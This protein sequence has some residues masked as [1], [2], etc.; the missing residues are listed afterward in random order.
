L[1]VL[2]DH[3]RYALAVEAC[4]DERADTVPARLIPLFE[5]YGL[6]WRILADNGPPWGDLHGPYTRLTVWLLRLGISVAHGRPYHPQ[7]QGKG[8]R[9]HRTLKAEVLAG[10]GFVDLATAQERFDRWRAS[11]NQERPHEGLA[12]ATPSSRYALSPRPYPVV[13]PTIEYRP[14][15]AVRKVQQEGEVHFAGRVVRV[16]KA[17]RGERVAVRPTQTDGVFTIYF[18]TDRIAQIDLRDPVE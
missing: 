17:L 15:D 13:V 10:A 5:R 6:P 14:E 16:S 7:T 1:T 8:E 3:S 18:M 12:M 4:G 11:D 9:F 2:D